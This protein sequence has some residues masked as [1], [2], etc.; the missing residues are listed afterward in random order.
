MSNSKKFNRW[1]DKVIKGLVSLGLELEDPGKRKNYKI[2]KGTINGKRYFQSFSK[3]PKSIT[4]AMKDI[5]SETKRKLLA[6]GVDISSFQD[7]MPTLGFL[8]I[9]MIEEKNKNRPYEQFS[10]ILSDIEKEL[11]EE[12]TKN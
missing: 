10:N 8:T 3:T 1:T 4:N 5:L 12:K 9:D 2:I 6:C 11:N 7:Q